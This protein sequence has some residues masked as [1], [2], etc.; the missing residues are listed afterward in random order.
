M[1]RRQINSSYGILDNLVSIKIVLIKIQL[2]VNVDEI[3]SGA[4]SWVQVQ[5]YIVYDAMLMLK[6]AYV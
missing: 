1:N 4:W 3:K 5:G 6:L 2:K